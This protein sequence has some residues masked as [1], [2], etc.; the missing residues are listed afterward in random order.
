M[1]VEHLGNPNASN[2]AKPNEGEQ[3]AND[4]EMKNIEDK[5]HGNLKQTYS[6]LSKFK[7]TY[8]V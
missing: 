1:Q 8:I 5:V 2:Y 3:T 6:T 7:L 4:I